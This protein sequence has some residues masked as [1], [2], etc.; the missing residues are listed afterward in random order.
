MDQEDKNVAMRDLWKQIDS[1]VTQLQSDIVDQNDLNIT[2]MQKV[3][4]LEGVIEGLEDRLTKLF[5][6][7]VE[8]EDIV[9]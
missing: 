8:V 7:I 4:H 5:D 3:D 2:Q 6:R 9:L 1:D